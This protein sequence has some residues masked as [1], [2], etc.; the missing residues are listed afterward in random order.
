VGWPAPNRFTLSGQG[1]QTLRRIKEALLTFFEVVAYGSLALL[2][3]SVL[4]GL[5]FGWVLAEI[6]AHVMLVAVAGL[7]VLT[8]MAIREGWYFDHMSGWW[9]TRNQVDPSFSATPSS[10]QGAQGGEA[11]LG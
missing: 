9:G 6:L 2:L 11:R 8:A 10:A 5:V 4:A 3:P 1:R 7:A